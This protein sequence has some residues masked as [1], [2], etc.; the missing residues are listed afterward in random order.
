MRR[1]LLIVLTTLPLSGF[2]Q[3]VQLSVG[4]TYVGQ[5]SFTGVPTIGLHT[6]FPM[7]KRLAV[8]VLATGARARQ[9]YPLYIWS[10]G[11]P[12]RTVSVVHNHLFSAQALVGYRTTLT[13][14]LGLVVGPTVGYTAIGRREQG[15]SD[16]LGAGLWAGVTYRRLWGTRFNLE[17]NINPRVLSQG[18]SAED[19]TMPFADTNLWLWDAQVGISYGLGL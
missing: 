16:K 4:Y 14:R 10:F 18:P 9:H 5:K 17:A 13:E 7:G 3:K 12:S 1:A 15:T 19:T 6:F 8:G 2:A 11:S